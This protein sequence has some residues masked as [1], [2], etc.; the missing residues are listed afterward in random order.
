MLP[1]QLLPDAH[2]LPPRVWLRARAF[3]VEQRSRPACQHRTQG[4]ALVQEDRAGTVEQLR[5]AAAPEPALQ[6]LQALELQ[7]PGPV[8]LEPVLRGKRGR[9]GA[10]RSRSG[11]PA[12]RS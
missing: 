10:G 9:S 12:R 6:G 8:C 5:R 7:P 4:Q 1:F 3:L 11:G 2:A